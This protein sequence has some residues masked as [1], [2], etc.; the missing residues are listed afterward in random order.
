MVF[1]FGKKCAP[2]AADQL[3]SGK[4][5]CASCDEWHNWPFDLAAF[6]PDPWPHE[7]A[8]EQ[9]SD[10]RFDG[11][12]LSEDFCILGG[13][14][15]MVRAILPVPVIGVPGDFAFGCW[16]TLSKTNFEKYIDGFDAGEYADAPQWTGWLMNRIAEFVPG[17]E[18]LGVIVQPQPGRQRPIIWVQDEDHPLAIAQSEGITAERVL[19]VFA[20]YGHA[21]AENGA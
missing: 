21:P 1:G 20:H 17:P 15:F 10:L 7:V 3:A 2:S 12:F 13:K 5:K 18:P 9:N 19:E 4:W 14:H 8:Y 6:A 11:D 16:S